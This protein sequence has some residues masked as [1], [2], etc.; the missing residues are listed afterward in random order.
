MKLRPFELA[1][2]LGFAL[3][4]AVALLLLANFQNSNRGE[5]T[6]GTVVIWGTLDGERMYELLQEL[7][8]A[9]D[10]YSDVSYRQIAAEELENQLVNALADGRGPDLLLVPHEQ[11]VSMRSRLR[12]ITYDSFPRR[13]IIDT[14]IDGAQIFA[15]N[16]GLYAYPIAVDPLLLYWNRALLAN[17]GFLNA[18]ATW[19]QLVNEYVPALIERD[20]NRQ[21]MR[22]VVAMGE[23]ENIRN[24]HGIVSTLLLQGGSEMVLEDGRQYSVLLDTSVSGSGRPL[25]SAAD[26]YTRFSRPSNTLYSWN[27][28]L[29]EDRQ[30]FLA[31]DLLLYF[32]Y[33]SEGVEI[34]QLNP[35]LSFGV[36]EVPQG[37][38]ATVR[39]TYGTFYGLGLL[40]AS[41]NIA[42]AA[43][44]MNI[45]SSPAVAARIAIDNDIVPAHRSSVATGS[46]DTYGRTAYSVAPVTYGWLNPEI[47][48]SRDIFSTMVR[49]IVEN[50]F[51]VSDAVRDAI[52]R[53]QVQYN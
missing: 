28:S 46:N 42:G 27:R 35:N 11:L 15:L 34:E 29:P 5:V 32:G 38:S 33:A 25:Q 20:A 31:E 14:Y 4:A 48:A 30:H 1:L 36:A 50:R 40:R 43:A 52:D 44:V 22:S 18:P 51:D 45:L 13:D 10:E 3:L 19:E 2:I 37:A 16:D 49:D 21:I 47:E 39:R 6:V 23:Y 53:L 7:A 17:A 8:D 41:D 26:F 12:P 24:A 9:Q